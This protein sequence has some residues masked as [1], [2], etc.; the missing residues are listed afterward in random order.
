ME[1]D[2]TAAF[3]AMIVLLKTKI[4]DSELDSMKFLCKDFIPGRI[5]DGLDNPLKLFEALEERNKLSATNLSFLKDLLRTACNKREDVLQ[6]VDNFERGNARANMCERRNTRVN[7][8]HIHLATDFDA[9]PTQESGLKE[10]FGVLENSLGREALHFLRRLGIEDDVLERLRADFP[11]DTKE[12]IHR[13]LRH[14]E[15]VE[16]PNADVNR[17]KEALKKENRNDLVDKIESVTIYSDNS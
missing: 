1:P 10:V 2:Q 14:W 7:N 5:R 3:R 11:R 6:I 15:D 4:T 17:I 8:Q 13:A 9:R 16:R 12:V